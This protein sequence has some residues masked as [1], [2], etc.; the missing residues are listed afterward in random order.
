MP[1]PFPGVDPYLEARGRWS[2]FHPRFL[3]H[4]CEAISEHLPESYIAQME[5][6]VRLGRP[7][8]RPGPNIR[9]DAGIL[10]REGPARGGRL[11]PAVALMEPI[12]VELESDYS[13]EP[14]QIWIEIRKLPDLELVTLIELLSPSN[15]AGWDRNDFLARRSEL[16]KRP[17]HLV[18]LDFLL[19]GQ[20]LPMRGPM[21][22]GVA[23]A[24]VSRVEDRPTAQV[25]AWTLHDP[26]PTIAI[27]LA[28]PDPDIAV[29]LAAPYTTAYERSRYGLILRYDRPLDLR[30][31][32]ENRAW[33][34]ALARGEPV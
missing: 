27:P 34:E 10:R 33:A 26:L 16:L 19:E 14:P 13:E 23:Y 6:Q 5:E 28:A 11:G 21:P 30:I 8:D 18:E 29:A 15:K 25:Y 17:I 20:R 22:A 2:D 9:P 24:I 1:S 7:G 31:A 32:A 4:L 3:T 12:S